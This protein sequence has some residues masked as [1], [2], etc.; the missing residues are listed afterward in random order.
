M[1]PQRAINEGTGETFQ[2]RAESNTTYTLTAREM[3]D[4]ATAAQE[5]VSAQYAHSWGLKAQIED[6]QS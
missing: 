2:F 6:A 4:V 1:L 5:H 3:Q